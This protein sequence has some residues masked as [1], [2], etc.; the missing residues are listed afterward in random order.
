MLSSFTKLEKSVIGLY[1]HTITSFRCGIKIE[2]SDRTMPRHTRKHTRKH[3]S[4]SHKAHHAKKHHGTKKSG[5]SDWNKKV[6]KVYHE[7]K[8]KNKNTKLG[9]AMRECSRRKKAGKL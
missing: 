6:M 1:D 2:R 8:A 7:M 3:N 9:D 5:A 4:K